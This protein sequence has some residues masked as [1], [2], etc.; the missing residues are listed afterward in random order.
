[1][2]KS[3]HSFP[4]IGIDLLGSDTAPEFLLEAVLQ[5]HQEGCSAELVVFGTAELF[6]NKSFPLETVVVKET[7]Q[8]E[9]SPAL[10]IRRKKDSSLYK[11]LKLLQDHRI[12]AFVSAGNT[13]ALLVGAKTLLS[14]LNPVERPA[15]LTLL[16]TAKKEM[17]LLDSGASV[18]CSPL[19]LF[20]FALMGRAYQKSRGIKN[21]TVGLLNIGTEK[22]KGSPLLRAAYE[23]L[24][25]LNREEF[26]FVGNIEGKEAFK[27]NVDVL[28]TDGFTGNIF[29]K[30]AE[31][32]AAF[33][34][35]ELSQSSYST[36]ILSKL[37]HRL[38]YVEFPGALLCGVE[39][40]VIKC[41]GDSSPAD[42]KSSIKGA[43]RLVKHQL[44]DKIKKELS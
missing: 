30:T 22:K 6:E 18:E 9:D 41:H 35:D 10:A 42:F 11:G 13:G 34:L 7:I 24:E 26:V 31:G 28:V 12:D 29:L 37:R 44:L 38:H 15:L 32:L 5:L 14:P 33:V 17:A 39:G 4:R 40:I 23:K 27:G 20:H 3:N 21:P 16:P 25:T 1:M 19:H 43:V 8:M 2:A 36:E